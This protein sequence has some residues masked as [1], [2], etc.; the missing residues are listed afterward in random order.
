MDYVKDTKDAYK[1][2]T[3]AKVY[4]EQYTK[5]FKWARFTMWRQRLIIKGLLN[6]CNF[7]ENDRILDIPCG[8]GFIGKILCGTPAD[9]TA[10]DISPE[11]IKRAKS[12]YKGD[13]FKGFVECDITKTP[14]E[15]ESFDCAI[16]LAFMHRLPREI[17][18]E[19]WREINRIS[20][21]YIIVNYG[22]DSLSQRIK[23]WVLKKISS[24]YESAPSS[25]PM[26]EILNEI[27]SFGFKI[28]SI[29]NV[30]YFFS[31][32]VIFL[33]EKNIENIK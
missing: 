16:I 21:K 19:T 20:K 23:K 13:N 1:T 14:F 11:M 30:V 31:G 22:F 7:N 12:E 29:T 24:K 15:N 4:Q 17:R 2:E 5:G 25:M 9:I 6:K 3:K 10:S 27:N 8:A 18:D 26:N 32:K 28:L 33:L